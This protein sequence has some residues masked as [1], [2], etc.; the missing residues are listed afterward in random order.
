MLTTLKTELISLHLASFLFSLKLHFCGR[1]HPPVLLSPP[2]YQF[3]DS[4]PSEAAGDT[5]AMHLPHLHAAPRQLSELPKYF[6]ANRLFGTSHPAG[7]SLGFLGAWLMAM[8]APRK[9]AMVGN[10]PCVAGGENSL[11]WTPLMSY[12]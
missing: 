7:A 11:P 1:E 9:Y 3:P 4:Q 5:T 6:P 2:N 8:Y 12:F 10:E